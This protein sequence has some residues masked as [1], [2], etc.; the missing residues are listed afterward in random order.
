MGVLIKDKIFVLVTFAVMLA[1]ADLIVFNVATDRHESCYECSDFPTCGDNSDKHLSGD[2]I[3][4]N[5]IIT[6]PVKPVFLQTSVSIHSTAFTD[7][8]ISKIWQPPKIS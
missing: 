6:Y 2:E 8:F 1:L 5:N 3:L 7:D 4:H